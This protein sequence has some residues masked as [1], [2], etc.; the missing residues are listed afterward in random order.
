MSWEATTA[1]TELTYTAMASSGTGQYLAAC[2]GQSDSNIITSAKVYLSADYGESWNVSTA[3]PAGLF[4][5][6][7]SSSTGQTLTVCSQSDGIYTSSDYGSN[8]SLSSDTSTIAMS[9]GS[10]VYTPSLVASASGQ[11]VY[12]LTY[13]AGLFYSSDYGVTWSS[14]SGAP[15]DNFY[16]SIASSPSGKYVVSITTLSKVYFSQNY[17]VSYALTAAPNTPW[18]SLFCS[19]SGVITISSAFSMYQSTNLGVTWNDFGDGSGGSLLNIATDAS[20]K[21]MIAYTS[22]GEVMQSTNGG[23][24]WFAPSSLSGSTLNPQSTAC[25]DDG[26]VQAFGTNG[27]GIYESR[28]S[29]PSS[30]ASSGEQ[31]LLL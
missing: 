31:M 7:T 8:W 6:I 21:N 1:I 13:L 10:T 24:H 27:H 25:N 26:S 30:S 11:Y 19:D 22:S 29:S 2:G 16:S 5:P 28:S 14:S 12:S 20:T 4:G 17:G 9:C 15:T 18:S 3:L 23:A